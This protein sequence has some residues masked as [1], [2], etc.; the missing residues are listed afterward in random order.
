MVL[1]ITIVKLDERRLMA[2]LSDATFDDRRERL[3]LEGQLRDASRIDTLTQIPNRAA[4]NDFLQALLDAKSAGPESNFAVMFIN[5]DRF[6]Q[7]NDALV[8]WLLAKGSAPV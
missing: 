8:A 6:R 1:A 7:I 2:S 3:A 4:L 5:C